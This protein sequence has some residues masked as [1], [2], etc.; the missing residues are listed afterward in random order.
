[1]LRAWRAPRG[2]ECSA[3]QSSLPRSSP[4]PLPSL[5]CGALPA[6]RSST[7]LHSERLDPPTFDAAGL[8]L[9]TTATGQLMQEPRAGL[10]VLA[11]ETGGAFAD[12][13]N[14]LRPAVARMSADMLPGAGHDQGAPSYGRVNDALRQALALGNRRLVERRKVS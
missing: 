7:R 12:G 2:E 13:S 8:R 6:W 14:D 10:S 1:M 3:R 11:R 4:P 9:H 5:P